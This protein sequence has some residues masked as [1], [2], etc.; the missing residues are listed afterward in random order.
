[1]EL[2][3][4]AVEEETKVLSYENIDFAGL[5]RRNRRAGAASAGNGK[6]GPYSNIEDMRP[7]GAPQQGPGLDVVHY[8]ETSSPAG[9]AGYQ[10]VAMQVRQG[11]LP[12]SCTNFSAEG[13]FAVWV[14]PL[15]EYAQAM[16]AMGFL[17]K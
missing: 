5:R 10:S 8:Y 3:E 1:M 11:M 14:V 4:R 9:L 15:N 17:T 6:T 2:R 16:A 7:K 13:G 12:G